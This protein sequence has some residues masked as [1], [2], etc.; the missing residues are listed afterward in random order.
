[1]VEQPETATA[2]E[3]TIGFRVMKIEARNFLGLKEVEITPTGNITCIKGRNGA[4]K[5]SILEAISLAFGGGLS[6]KHIHKGED[7]AEI[8]LDLDAFSIHRK[9]TAAGTKTL[10]VFSGEGFER[11]KPQAYLDAIVGKFAFNPI[12]FSFAPAKERNDILLS[13]LEV[14]YSPADALADGV[15]TESDLDAEP[16]LSNLTGLNLV[17]ALEKFHFG[18]RTDINRNLKSAENTLSELKA[19]LPADFEAFDQ[20]AYDK[21]EKETEKV[22]DK[23]ATAEKEE[24]GATLALANEVRKLAQI[25]E[26][27]G[28]L[29]FVQATFVDAF[30]EEATRIE[31]M[32]TGIAALCRELETKKGK[33]ETMRESMAHF[34]I[35]TEIDTLEKRIPNGERISKELSEMIEKLRGEIKTRLISSADLSIDGLT[36]A[37]GAFLVNEIEIELLS[38]SEKLKIGLEI[39]KKL[40]DKFRIL[41]VDGV[42]KLD[43]ETLKEFAD[44]IA[45]SGFQCFMTTC[46]DG[47]ADVQTVEIKKD[48]Q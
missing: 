14:A 25:K 10:K 11:S 7:S 44:N 17:N 43:S 42:E 16:G 31:K 13:A 18:R 40:N 2:N 28:E 15:W 30:K 19:K 37:D 24:S 6:E 8:L 4:G 5:T 9:I 29:K 35:Q 3:K 32:K 45:A 34:G 39:A 22:R 12:D 41:C 33:L 26:D 38:E 21:L 46:H 23:I 20:V 27:V 48:E 47:P 1:M 36:F